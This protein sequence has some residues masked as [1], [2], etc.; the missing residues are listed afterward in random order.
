MKAVMVGIVASLK[1]V[2][3]GLENRNRV[4]FPARE[5]IIFL[6]TM[7]RTTLGSTL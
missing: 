5:E 1:A 6:T 4:Q 2:I 3:V 7:S